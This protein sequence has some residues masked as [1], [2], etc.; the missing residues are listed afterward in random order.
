MAVPLGIHQSPD[1]QAT[2]DAV[3]LEE[4]PV[5]PNVLPASAKISNAREICS[6]SCAAETETRSSDSA[7]GVA[8]GIAILV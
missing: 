4:L 5:R 3:K 7:F 1:R 8:G 6:S 2:L